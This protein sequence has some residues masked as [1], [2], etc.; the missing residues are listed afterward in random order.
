MKYLIIYILVLL[1]VITLKAQ[2]THAEEITTKINWV[3]LAEAE[4][5]CKDSANTKKIYVFFQTDWCVFCRHMERTTFQNDEL[6]AYMNKNFWS[7]RFNTELSDTVKFNKKAYTLTRHRGWNCNG[8]AAEYLDEKLS[9]PANLIIDEHLNKMAALGGAQSAYQL[10]TLMTYFH[11]GHYKTTDLE[12]YGNSY[13][14]P[15]W[16]GA[17]GGRSGT[18]RRR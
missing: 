18:V 3:T 1:Q 10:M 17:G 14:L 2:P 6:A 12:T 5:R 13:K 8:F 7:V 11:E 4:A 15:S 9:F 16:N